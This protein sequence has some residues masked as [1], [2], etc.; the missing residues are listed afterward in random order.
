MGKRRLLLVGVAATVI[1]LDQLTKWWALE[2]LADGNVIDVVWTLRFALTYNTGTAFSFGGGSGI[3]PWIAVLALGVVGVVI[4]Q[5]RLVTSRWGSV[6]LGLIAGGALGNII[7]RAARGDTGFM[8]GAVVDFIDL[9]WWPVFNVA[10]AAI[11]VGA[12][13]LLATL[14]FGP[15]GATPDSAAV[16]AAPAESV[17]DAD[18]T[19]EP[20][21]ESPR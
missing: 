14:L 5:S 18:H 2:E 1:V 8:S 7:D 19:T 9:R 15:D 21:D 3:G 4:W 13:L 10:D 6:A 17:P 20:D 12:I 16:D 11:V